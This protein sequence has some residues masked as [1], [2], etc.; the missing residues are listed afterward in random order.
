MKK[1][2]LLAAIAA[3]SASNAY[4]GDLM[5]HGDND[6]MMG[7][8]YFSIKVGANFASDSEAKLSTS[9]DVFGTGTSTVTGTGNTTVVTTDGALMANGNNSKFVYKTG[10]GGAVAAGMMFENFKADVELLYLSSPSSDNESGKTYKTVKLT[11]IQVGPTATLLL[12]QFSPQP[13]IDNEDGYT[14]YSVLVNGLASVALAEDFSLS[15]GVGIGFGTTKVLDVKTNGIVWQ[16]KADLEFSMS[17]SM[18]A[19]IG[20]RHLRPLADEVK[21]A[22]F[23]AKVNV[24]LLLLLVLLLLV[25]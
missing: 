2:F 21:D 24:L 23:T 19:T 25:T 15:A 11:G 12:Q 1:T 5:M 22:S 20:V 4:A 13:D 16:A 7:G 17:D 18:C 9:D 8:N 14:N 10:F 3:V 6:D